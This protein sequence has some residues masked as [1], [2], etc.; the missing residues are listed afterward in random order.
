MFT[1]V[2]EMQWFLRLHLFLR[3]TRK[4]AT[5]EENAKT[6]AFQKVKTN[7]AVF[8]PEVIQELSPLYIY[9]VL[10]AKIREDKKSKK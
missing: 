10:L 6:S 2:Y 5:M 7:E 9:I 8:M 3:K 4:C 1:V